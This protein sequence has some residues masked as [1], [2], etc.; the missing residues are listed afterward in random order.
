MWNLPTTK[1]KDGNEL[2]TQPTSV[3][4]HTLQN[5][6]PRSLTFHPS[7][8]SQTNLAQHGQKS[9]CSGPEIIFPTKP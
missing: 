9:T 2:H 3:Q 8:S 6:A 4:F 5:Y 7:A 1:Y